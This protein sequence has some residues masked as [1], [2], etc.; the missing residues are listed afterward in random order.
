MSAPRSSP[1]HT[2]QAGEGAGGGT[3]A[4][5]QDGELPLGQQVG[6]PY[7]G[8]NE[9][10]SSHSLSLNTESSLSNSKS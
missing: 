8:G 6:G 2:L 5:K 3:G 7:L 1:C 4:Q 10:P 9:M